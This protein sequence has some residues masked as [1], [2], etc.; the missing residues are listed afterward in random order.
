VFILFILFA[1]HSFD[2]NTIV[3]MLPPNS[4]NNWIGYAFLESL[5]YVVVQVAMSSELYIVL[6]VGKLD[7]HG[8]Q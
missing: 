8:K 6:T 3:L 7:T 2:N 5:K 4:K 1:Y